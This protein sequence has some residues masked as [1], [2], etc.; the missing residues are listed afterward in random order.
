MLR[1]AA[2]AVVVVA[3]ITQ[4]GELGLKGADC[5]KDVGCVFSDD[6]NG[7][8]CFYDLATG[9]TSLLSSSAVT[10]PRDIALSRDGKIAVVSDW[11]AGRLTTI[12]VKSQAVA[13]F[14]CL[15]RDDW[16]YDAGSDAEIPV[17]LSRGL[18][19]Y[20]YSSGDGEIA[21]VEDDAA[22]C[23]EAMPEGVALLSGGRYAAVNLAAS[24]QLAI[25]DLDLGR[26]KTILAPGDARA[27]SQ[28]LTGLK[29]HGLSVSGSADAP[30][31][32]GAVYAP[33]A[34]ESALYAVDPVTGHFERS[35]VMG[36]ASHWFDV[37]AVPTTGDRSHFV[38]LDRAARGVFLVKTA[39]DYV[40]KQPSDDVS[41]SLLAGSDKGEAGFEDGYGSDARFDDFHAVGSYDDESVVVADLGNHALRR[42][43]F[44][45]S[46]K[47]KV[48]T[49]VAFDKHTSCGAAAAAVD[50]EAAVVAD[51]VAV[52]A[53]TASS[54]KRTASYSFEYFGMPVL[55]IAAFA[56][57][58]AASAVLQRKGRS[59]PAYSPIPTISTCRA[60]Y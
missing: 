11:G 43:W 55:L 39:R 41:L 52:T 28:S 23:A 10:A 25:V 1:R 24:G 21:F 27:L 8:V 13:H 51:A 35:V 53:Q 37:E 14:D 36:P 16:W 57:L 2:V 47:G 34:G 31:V 30:W 50:E 60:C 7:E 49:L 58:V 45:G 56:G 59:R 48:A 38:V 46:K 42:V 6:D 32:V 54:K 44:A 4:G 12:N 33:D 5:V 22:A 40:G 26:H 9:E 18:L 29:I 20:S 15:G 3:R 17:P 19:S